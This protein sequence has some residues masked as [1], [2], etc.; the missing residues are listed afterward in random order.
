MRL[1][2]P[3][4]IRAAGVY[5]SSVPC[6]LKNACELLSLTTSHNWSRVGHST[7]FG[8]RYTLKYLCFLTRK[9]VSLAQ[10]VPARVVLG[11]SG[12]AVRLRLRGPGQLAGAVRLEVEGP[13]GP[14]LSTSAIRLEVEG[15]EGPGLSAGAI[16]LEM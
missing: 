5:S 14:G 8:N 1:I 11:M 10:A 2:R 13:E 15:P 9:G 3:T 4:K 16:R 7:W 6:D 12:D